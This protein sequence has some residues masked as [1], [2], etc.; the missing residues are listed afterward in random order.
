MIKNLSDNGRGEIIFF[1]RT[2]LTTVLNNM[3]ALMK[4]VW[5]QIKKITYFSKIG[6]D[7]IIND[8][9]H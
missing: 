3:Q 6:L 5:F 4:D 7:I 2:Y 8:F 9:H 1:F